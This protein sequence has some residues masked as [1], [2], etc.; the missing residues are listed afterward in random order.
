MPKLTIPPLLAEEFATVEAVWNSSGSTRR[1]DSLVLSWVKYEKQLRRLFCFI[2][3]QHS[4]LTPTDIESVVGILAANNKLYPETFIAGIEEL[5]ARAVKVLLASRYAELWAE[6][7]RI[8]AYRNKLIHGQ[9]TGLKITSRQLERDVLWIVDWI[10]T[11]AGAAQATF[12]YDG[13][14]RNTYRAA[15]AASII[16]ITTYPFKTAAE[17][18]TWLATLARR[19]P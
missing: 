10:N 12:G 19:R 4:G 11:L 9:I 6:I 15:K 3:F 7:S 18:E 5:S 2:V 13:I 14:Q 17:F 1:V 8:K 16:A